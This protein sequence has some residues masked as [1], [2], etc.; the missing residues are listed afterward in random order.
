MLK[1]S[2][3]LHDFLKPYCG[4]RLIADRKYYLPTIE[5]INL[6]LDEGFI[7]YYKYR[8]ETFDC[9]DFALILHAWIRQEQYKQ[10]WNYPLAFGECWGEFETNI[11]HAMNFAITNEEKFIL[12]EP[13][14][15][16][17]KRYES[18][19]TFFALRM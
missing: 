4:L 2:S 1:T 12:I 18:D 13:Q 3:Q 17:V 5:E 14:T 6:L 8:I 16:E 10:K 19:D 11:Y 9:D 7:E 15:D